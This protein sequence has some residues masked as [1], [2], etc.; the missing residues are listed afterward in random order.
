MLSS[1]AGLLTD[2]SFLSVF[3]AAML[4]TPLSLP[5]NYFY[6]RLVKGAPSGTECPAAEADGAVPSL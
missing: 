3:C 2:Q 1:A 6:N 4:H 5:F